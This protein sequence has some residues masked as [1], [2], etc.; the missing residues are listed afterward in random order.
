M[1]LPVM[2]SANILSYKISEIELVYKS[3]VKASQR[4]LVR[5]SASAY[6]ILLHSWDENKLDFVEQFKVMLLNRGNKVIGICNISSGG[7]SSTI[8]D[9]RLIL[10]AALKSGAS[11]IVLAHNHPSGNL[12][13]SDADKKLT[14]KITES[15]ALMDIKTLDHIILTSEGYYSFSDDQ[16]YHRPFDELLP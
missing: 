14:D 6:S 4:P 5:D 1:E 7:I 11:S 3:K 10:V 15:S 9:I 8:A 2:D 12:Q 13:P 16:S